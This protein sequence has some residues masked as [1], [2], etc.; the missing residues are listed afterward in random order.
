MWLW[1]RNA[2]IPTLHPIRPSRWMIAGCRSCPSPAAIQSLRT[3]RPRVDRRPSSCVPPTCTPGDGLL[4]GDRRVSCRPALVLVDGDRTAGPDGER[5]ARDR[6]VR[7]PGRFEPRIDCLKRALRLGSADIYDAEPLGQD[8]RDRA[9][10]RSPRRPAVPA[11]RQARGSRRRAASARPER[12]RSAR[13]R[14]DPRAPPAHTSTRIP[15]FS[16]AHGS[17][18]DQ[19]PRRSRSKTARSIAGPPHTKRTLT[20]RKIAARA[21]AE[22]RDRQPFAEPVV[23]P[24][25]LYR[26]ASSSPH[27]G[28]IR[29]QSS[30]A[31]SPSARSRPRVYPPFV[32]V[33]RIIRAACSGS[34]WTHS[35]G[36][37]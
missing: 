36:Y 37:C 6:A 23:C 21:G 13:G 31:A 12:R 26:S 5:P 35:A 30:S 34:G 3:V 28:A 1:P 2:K 24:A 29:P 8:G 11:F 18:A 33:A 19:Y 16:S 4:L 32:P 22:S 7:P 17:A 10:P 20:A 25:E 27:N 15:C 14:P 9:L